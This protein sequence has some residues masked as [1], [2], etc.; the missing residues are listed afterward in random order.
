[1]CNSPCVSIKKLRR[2]SHI[3]VPKRAAAYS[4]SM[5][6]KSIASHLRPY[7]MVARRRTTIN[8]AFAAAVAP[9][10]IYDEATVSEAMMMLGIDPSGDL[11]CAYCGEPAETWDHIF[12]TVRN[13]RF[14]GHGHRLGNLL[15]CC[16]PCNSKK[17]NKAWHVHLRSLAMADD[18]RAKRESAI[19]SF[20]DRYGVLE[21]AINT[22]PDHDRLEAIRLQVL[23]LLTE[24]DAIAARIRQSSMSA[25]NVSNT[26]T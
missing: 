3:L 19:A 5:R 12:A 15:P 6:I 11:D 23:E 16:K 13:S 26:D 9:S 21:P 22:S 7:V 25:D 4:H 24:G 17:G 10:D 20:I 1:M 8:H 18:L 14:S 2:P